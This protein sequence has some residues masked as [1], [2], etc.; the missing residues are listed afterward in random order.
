MVKSFI[1]KREVSLL[2]ICLALSF[3][4]GGCKKCI[5]CT[6]KV[7]GYSQE[8]CGTSAQV[9]KYEKELKELGSKVGQT[10][11]CIDK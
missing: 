9:N 8:Y 3:C 4:I 6:E 10:W 7:S 1:M 11:T 2:L 5:T